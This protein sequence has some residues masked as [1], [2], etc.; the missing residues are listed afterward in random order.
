MFWVV[1]SI[2]FKKVRKTDLEYL[3][4]NAI[5]TLPILLAAAAAVKRVVF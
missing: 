2:K 4:E 5:L 1:Y 3:N